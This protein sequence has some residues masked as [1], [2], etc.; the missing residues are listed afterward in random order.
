[1]SKF[2]SIKRGLGKRFERGNR[3]GQDRPVGSSNKATI[4]IQDLL[5]GEGEAI[6]RKA[7][8]LAKAGIEKPHS[9]YVWIV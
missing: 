5:D 4:A 1:M 8:R 9:G 6:T 2:M 7:I 3:F